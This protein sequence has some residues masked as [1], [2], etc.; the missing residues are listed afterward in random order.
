MTHLIHK[1]IIGFLLI[2][3][4]GPSPSMSARQSGAAAKGTSAAT[5]ACSL[6]TKNEVKKLAASDDPFFDRVPAREESVGL[7]GSACFYSGIV[8]QVDP[9]SP[10]TLEEHRKKRGQKWQPLTGVGETGY[11]FD[12]NNAAAALHHAELYAVVGTHVLTIQMGV[13][14]AEASIDTVRPALLN[15]AKAL[16]AKLR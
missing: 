11:L 3:F 12:N 10:A 4:A 13:H 16:A 6:L 15:L 5:R 9:F 14:P 1:S 8:I 2:V 7:S